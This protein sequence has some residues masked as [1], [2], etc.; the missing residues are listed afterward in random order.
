M[1]VRFFGSNKCVNCLEFFVILNKAQIE[2]SY[3]DALAKDK[4]IQKLCDK[5]DV[6]ELPHIQFLDDKEEVVLEHR[7]KMTENQFI[8]ILSNFFPYY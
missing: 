5:N 6:W 8:N 3:I 1:K 4:D 7:G 2:Y